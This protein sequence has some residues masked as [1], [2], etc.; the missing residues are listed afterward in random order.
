MTFRWKLAQ[1]AESLWWKNYLSDRPVQAY[2]TWKKNYWKDFLANNKIRILPSDK[3]LDAGCGP[4][5]IFTV[6]TDNK[7]TAIDPLCDTYERQLDHF[8][9]SSYPYVDFIEKGLEEFVSQNKYDKIFCI[10]AIN[11]VKDLNLCLKNL[12]KSLMKNGFL[13]LTVDAHNYIFLKK[14]FQFFPGDILHP[15]QL[16][17]NDYKKRIIKYNAVIQDITLIKKESIFNYYLFTI[18][19][20]N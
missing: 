19:K 1:F 13:Y 14:I 16:D 3:I 7:V 20:T 8:Q 2:L 4:A 17:L 15:H 5:G 12:M 9:K 18:Q 10:N 11:H 6:L